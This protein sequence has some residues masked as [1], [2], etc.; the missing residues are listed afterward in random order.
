MQFQ[1]KKVQ[2]KRRPKMV[3]P[4]LQ[5]AVG[6][7]ILR[8]ATLWDAIVGTI[9]MQMKKEGCSKITC[10]E[11]MIENK[12]TLGKAVVAREMFMC[13]EKWLQLQ[14]RLDTHVPKWW[15]D[16]DIVIYCGDNGPK[17]SSILGGPWRALA[18]N[19]RGV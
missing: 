10:L 5:K 1:I 2:V 18:A 9:E 15:L 16:V 7:T 3:C 6:I 12:M 8:D 14:V 4:I 11:Q 19:H 13:K 17:G